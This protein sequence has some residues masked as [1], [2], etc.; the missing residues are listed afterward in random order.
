MKEEEVKKG[1]IRC[2]GVCSSLIPF[3]LCNIIRV[4]KVICDSSGRQGNVMCR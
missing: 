3:V 4:S 1:Q 2:D